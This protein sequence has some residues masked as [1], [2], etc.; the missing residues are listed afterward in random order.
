MI[1]QWGA[2]Q[3]HTVYMY[4]PADLVLHASQKKKKKKSTVANG[5]IRVR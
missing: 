1:E 4:V 3:D 2:E 5:R